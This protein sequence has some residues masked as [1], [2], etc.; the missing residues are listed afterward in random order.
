MHQHSHLKHAGNLRRIGQRNRGAEAQRP[1]RLIGK[2]SPSD[3]HTEN[4]A[5]KSVEKELY[6]YQKSLTY[7]FY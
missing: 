3:L 4:T 7:Q 1:C 2:T 5:E 6:L